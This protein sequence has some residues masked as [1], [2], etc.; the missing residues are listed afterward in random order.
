MDR[1]IRFLLLTT[2]LAFSS[3]FSAV[4]EG[5]EIP[6]KFRND[7][8]QL[9]NISI[10]RLYDGQKDDA[11]KDDYEYICYCSKQIMQFLN[12]LDRLDSKKYK[13]LIGNYRLV[14]N[15]KN[16]IEPRNHFFLSDYVSILIIEDGFLSFQSNDSTSSIYI[17]SLGNMFFQSRWIEAIRQIRIY[18][19]KMYIYIL[20]EDYWVLDSIHDGGKYFFLKID[21]NVPDEPFDMNEWFK[22]L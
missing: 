18:D 1:I 15:K 3:T 12:S 4:S 5:Q 17:D 20:D 9:S 22:K 6:N 11:S 13:R 7:E 21:S 14:D 10:Q 19:E 2:Y 16:N 8:K